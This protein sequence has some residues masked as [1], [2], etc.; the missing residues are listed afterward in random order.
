MPAIWKARKVAVEMDEQPVSVQVRMR[1][2]I[3]R[4]DKLLSLGTWGIAAGLVVYS[5]MT[6][7][8]FVAAHSPKGWEATAP[9]LPAV[10][11]IAFLI[12][13]QA[14]SVLSR[15]RQSG[16]WWPGLLRWVT[17]A[18]SV[19]LND[20]ASVLHRDW[21]GVPVH[22]IA[23]VVLLLA[24]EAGPAYR[25]AMGRAREEVRKEEARLR[26]EARRERAAERAQELAERQE[27][28]AE[29]AAVLAE[30]ER[31]E[32]RAEWREH[33]TSQQ[34]SKPESQQ[35]P[36]P[37][38]AAPLPAAPAPW[39]PEQPVYVE[40]AAVEQQ[41]APVAAARHTAPAGQVTMPV[42]SLR[43]HPAQEDQDETDTEQ[44]L[45][46]PREEEAEDDTETVRLT[47]AAAKAVIVHG[48][49]AGRSTRETAKDATRSPA[50]VQKLYTRLNENG[51]I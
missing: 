42:D 31:Q 40:P 49:K 23:P 25:R 6:G 43:E 5:L 20:A 8:P 3:G 15:Y 30:Q 21:T 19:Y 16:G 2:E 1:A 36:M 32:D 39:A 44:L 9:I 48:W 51:A 17:G 7:T 24:A 41:R 47:E 13:L 28:R 29:R 35:A 18:A 14:D 37:P 50:F 4:M 10:V 33:R 11:D 22:L 26:E 46:A 34:A 38:L 45:P 27:D 12:S